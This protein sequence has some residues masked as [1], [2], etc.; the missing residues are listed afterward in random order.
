[1]FVRTAQAGIP[2]LLA[3]RLA[4]DAPTAPVAVARCKTY[5]AAELVPTMQKM[6]DQ[7]GGLGRLVKGKTVAIKINL[8]GAP[9]YRL[10]YLPLEDTHYTH[11]QVIAAAVHLMGKAG[12]RR[13][14]LLE[15]PWSTAD[16]VEE[17]IL[18]ANWEPRDMLNAATNVEFENTNYLGQ[19]KKY[20]RMK[21]PFGGYIFPA[22]DLNHSYEDC[23]VFVS[24]AKMKEHAT[25]GITLS[26]KNC[27]GLTPCTIYGTGA[28]K[29]EPSLVPKGGRSMVHAGDRQPSASAPAEKDP[30]TPRQDTYR[31]PRTVVDLISARPIHLAIVEGIKTMTGGEGPWVAGDLQP[32]A[33]GVILAGLNPVTTDAVSMA[34]MGFDPMADRGTP[35]FE[36]CD[37]TLKLAEAA[38]VGTRDLKRIEIIGASLAEARFDFAGMRKKRQA[39]PMPR[40]GIRG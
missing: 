18:R 25:A 14:R 32:V 29:D 17:Y 6:F 9:T 12:A 10:G 20:S 40:M 3:R 8:T 31:V 24:I 13:I 36:R 26:M 23:D 7:L 2:A 27:F 22:F 30:A 4:A 33:P 15:S 34:V 1:L 21:V 39:S 38:G 28:G 19:A 35:P 37:S 11:P 16:P 5:N